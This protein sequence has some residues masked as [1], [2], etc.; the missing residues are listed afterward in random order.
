MLSLN[1]TEKHPSYTHPSY[2]CLSYTRL[3]YTRLS[4]TFL[5]P[6]PHE[7]AIHR[8]AAHGSVSL[9]LEAEDAT[10]PH[11]QRA[12]LARR[13]HRILWQAAKLA[14]RRVAAAGVDDPP[15]RRLRDG[16]LLPN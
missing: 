5:T 3:S 15:V 11:P 2:T 7:E 4:Y 1:S 14:Q 10:P 16:I 9:R 8:R 12:R 13:P 6:S